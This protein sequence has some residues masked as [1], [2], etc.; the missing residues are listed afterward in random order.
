[1]DDLRNVALPLMWVRATLLAPAT[2]RSPALFA[3][4]GSA[5]ASRRRPPYVQHF[6]VQEGLSLQ[7]KARGAPPAGGGSVLF[8]CPTVQ[9]LKSCLVTDTGFVKRIRC[10]QCPTVRPLE[11]QCSKPDPCV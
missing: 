4:A 8:H 7:I 10:E 2:G 6:G 5:D 3:R 1:M 11:V 9:E